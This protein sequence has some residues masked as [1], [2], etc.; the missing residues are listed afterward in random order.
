MKITYYVATSQDYFIAKLDG[1]V[2]WLDEQNID[3]DEAG[4]DNFFSD[5]DGLVMGRNTYDFIFNYGSWPYGNIPSWICT[6]RNLNVLDDANIQI[7]PSPDLVINQARNKGINH[8]WLVGGGKLASSFLEKKLITD[9]FIAKMPI[10]L[11]VGIP[12]FAKHNLEN[13][14]KKSTKINL[15][16]NFEQLHITLD[17]W[18][19]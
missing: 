4:Y 18:I 2:S 6:N 9:L 8:L 11:K 5:I 14:I 1:D 16:S 19:I 12:L 7:T 3:E 15:K 17:N 13:I 10:I